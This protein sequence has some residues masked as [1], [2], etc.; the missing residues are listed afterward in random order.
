MVWTKLAQD[1]VGLSRRIVKHR[2]NGALP[3]TN[4][5]RTQMFGLLPVRIE[6]WL[7]RWHGICLSPERRLTAVYLYA[8]WTWKLGMNVSSRRLASASVPPAR[9]ILSRSSNIALL[10]PIPLYR[11]L[12]RAHRRFLPRDMRLLGDEYVKAEFRAHRNVDN[13]VHIVRRNFPCMRNS[14]AAVANIS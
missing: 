8:F 11:R 14:V 4:F 3:R 13:P 6:R 12:L 7:T 10:P 5:P 2:V 9:N 1:F